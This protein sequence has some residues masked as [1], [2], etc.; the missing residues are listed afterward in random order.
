M[1]HRLTAGCPI[2]SALGARI[3]PPTR[4]LVRV[5]SRHSLGLHSA[6]PLTCRCG[7][8]SGAGHKPE[9]RGRTESPPSPTLGACAADARSTWPFARSSGGALAHA[10]SAR[11]LQPLKRNLENW[12][13]KCLLFSTGQIRS[14]LPDPDSNALI[15]TK[16]PE[17]VNTGSGK[18]SVS[19]DM[20][21]LSRIRRT[22]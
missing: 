3:R 12:T 7:R 8:P 22:S 21:R 14:L 16:L 2:A 19:R 20:N 1:W 5:L 4:T 10:F 13:H 6:W 15:L 9:I 18:N 11:T 17:P